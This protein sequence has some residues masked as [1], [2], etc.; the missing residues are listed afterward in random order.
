M[1]TIQIKHLK[2]SDFRAQSRELDFSRRVVIEGPNGSGK[3]TV[4]D[5]FL[6][7]IY[8]LDSEGR[9]NYNLFDDRKE[10][11]YEN[12]TPA[13]VEGIFILNGEDI[14]LRKV[15]KQRW[16]RP[17]GSAEYVK[18]T[19]DE[20]K[21]YINGLEVTATAYKDFITENFGPV[22]K[23]PL[24]LNVRYFIDEDWKKL[25]AHFANLVEKVTDAD[26]QGDYTSIET[27]LSKYGS[28]NAK[29]YLRQQINPLKEQSDKLE[30]DIKASTNNLPNLT[31]VESAE[32]RIQEI[33]ETLR[34]ID[35]SILDESERIRPYSEKR[36]AEQVEILRKQTE[37]TKAASAWDASQRT[38]VREAEHN[39]RKKQ[40]DN[41]EIARYN[42]SLIRRKSS[43]EQLITSCKDNI[44]FAKEMLSQ[45]REDSEA[46][47]HKV[48]ESKCEYCGQTLPADMVESAKA[49]FDAKQK[50]DRE[51]LAKRG[52]AL[53]DKV[54]ACEKDL[55]EYQ[56]QLNEIVPREPI[57]LQPYKDAIENAKAM[58]VPF[59]QT[60][61]A[62][63]L[64]REIE[65]LQAN[66]TEIPHRDTT[67]LESRRDA[68]LAELSEQSR[69]L[70]LR[71]IYA[72]GVANIDKLKY[73][74]QLTA[75][76]MA[77][78]EGQLQKIIERER[79]WASI[80][81]ERAN[82]NLH[83]CQLEMLDFD[84]SGNLRDT[85]SISIDGV[86]VS[87]TNSANKLR[88]GIDI[89]MAFMARYGVK[90][91]I[92]IDNAEQITE[93]NIPDIDTQVIAMY[94]SDNG[95]FKSTLYA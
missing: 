88:A 94:V 74:R 68:A 80:V 21:F 89:A 15:A 93:N 22:D 39:L 60:Q 5:A 47:K 79:E 51:N 27:I 78:F 20:Y 25:R 62:Q 55:A 81:R 54:E 34:Q 72:R 53:R 90:L 45:L 77:L 73:D 87:V 19:S 12:A 13:E 91:P 8:G 42:E 17:R 37:L 59:E 7:L 2:L 16:I 28:T 92:F 1:N 67:E 18:D 30:A 64:K 3:S 11:K 49:E 14:A 4:L 33:N 58:I 23:L 10:L 56:K 66:M 32:K 29:D 86:D 9:F 76:R 41:E 63:D 82:K 83:L 6:W 50:Q 61:Q 26:L 75:E 95:E 44:A 24:M 40:M 69:I 71:D 43:I 52:W 48:F 85:C 84:K 46:V 38:E 36:A 35:A 70:G 31:P 65:N 57:D